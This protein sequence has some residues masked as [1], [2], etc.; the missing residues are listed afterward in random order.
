MNTNETSTLLTIVST[1]TD[2]L[3]GWEQDEADRVACNAMLSLNIAS[4]HSDACLDKPSL[5]DACLDRP[6]L[7]EC[8]RGDAWRSEFSMVH[9]ATRRVKFPVL[10]GKWQSFVAV[11][12]EVDGAAC[13]SKSNSHRVRDLAA[14]HYHSVADQALFVELVKLASTRLDEPARNR[15]VQVGVGYFVDEAG[16][17]R[18]KYKADNSNSEYLMYNVTYTATIVSKCLLPFPISAYTIPELGAFY[19]MGHYA[20]AV[21]IDAAATGH[22]CMSRVPKRRRS[23]L[24][25]VLYDVFGNILIV[26]QS[27]AWHFQWLGTFRPAARSSRRGGHDFENMYA[28]TSSQACSPAL[29]RISDTDLASLA[30]L[31]IQ[32]QCDEISCGLFDLT[33]T[34][35]HVHLPL[36]CLGPVD[37]ANAPCCLF[38][39][40][41]APSINNRSDKLWPLISSVAY[42]KVKANFTQGAYTRVSH[43]EWRPQSFNYQNTTRMVSSEHRLALVFANQ[44]VVRWS[45]PPITRDDV[46]NGTITS[47]HRRVMSDTAGISYLSRMAIRRVFSDINRQALVRTHLFV[48]VFANSL[49]VTMCSCQQASNPN[50]PSEFHTEDDASVVFALQEV[51]AAVLWAMNTD[52]F[53]HNVATPDHDIRTVQCCFQ[54]IINDFN[55]L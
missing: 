35:N 19:A 44:Y 37:F 13:F 47:L 15:K 36:V 30:N 53:T 28:S 21:S 27:V 45:Q 5:G 33:P 14:M 29:C 20:S 40:S 6:S 17:M 12:K 18:F 49:I 22:E 23:Q 25:P 4:T 11:S 32:T 42:A 48:F 9:T 50:T 3:F 31:N 26:S 41:I 8:A 39:F 2:D 55:K 46:G 51:C 1:V 38:P 7:G 10:P 16:F 54:T 34:N 52:Q 24:V 43:A